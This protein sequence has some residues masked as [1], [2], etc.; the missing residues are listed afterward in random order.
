MQTNDGVYLVALPFT[1]DPGPILGIAIYRSIDGGRTWGSPNLIH[2]SELP[3]QD[4]KQWAV[5]D[6]NPISP[7]FG[8]VYGVWDGGGIGT[9]KL[10]FARTIDHGETWIG[11]KDKKAGSEIPGIQDSG[12]P[13]I[14]VASD[15]TIYVVWLGNNSR[16]VK[17]VRSTDGGDSFTSPI[18]VAKGIVPLLYPYIENTHGWSHFLEQHFV[19]ERIALD[20]LR[21]VIT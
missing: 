14:S 13:E 21:L 2:P 12:A 3:E 11:L 18:V 9:A 17:F 8:N 15:G 19:W 7:Y 1:P 5:G 10:R 6:N 16:D 4:D 20:A